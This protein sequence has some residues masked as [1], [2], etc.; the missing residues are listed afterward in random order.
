MTVSEYEA[1]FHELSRHAAMILPTEEERVR[2]FVRGLRLQLRIETQSLVSAGRSFLDVVDHART[3]EQLRREAQEGSGKRARQ[4]DSCDRR[5]FRPRESYDRSQQRFHSGQSSSPFQASLQ[6]SKGDQHCHIGFSVGPSRGRDSS[7]MGSSGRGSRPPA[8]SRQSQGCYECRELD[9]WARECPHRRLALPAPQAVRHAPA[10]S[11]RGRG[12]GQD[13]RGG[14]QGIRGG[15]RGGRLGGRADAQGRG[16]QAHFYAAPARADAETSDDVITGTVLLCQQPALALFDPGSTFSYVSVYYASRLS[17]M[18]EPL[19][20]P[21]RVSTPVGESLVVDQVF[22][23]CLVTIQ[24]HDTRADLILLDMVDFD[25]ILG[26]D[27]LSP[28]RAVLDCFSK[29]VTL[30]I[31]GIPP[32]VWQGSRSS[33]PVG[34]ISFIRARRLVASGCLSYLAYVRDVSR[35]VSPVESVPVVRDFIDVFPTDLPGLPPER[36]V[37]F[38]IELEPGTRPIFIPPYRMAPAELKELS[39]QLQDL[40]GKGFIRPSV[41]PWGAP[42]LFVK[43]KDGTM[44][45]CIDYR[46]LNKVTVKN[47]YPMPRINDLFDQLQGAVV[48]SKIDLRSGYHQ[49]RI[50]AADV[51]K[52]AFRTRY[53]HYEFLVMS[54]GLTNAPAAFMDLMTRVFRPYLDLFVIVFI[55]DILVYSRSRNKQHLRIVLQTLR[56][57]RLYAKFSKCEFWLESVAFLGHVVSKEGIRVDPAKIEAIRDWHRPTSVTEIRSFVGLAGYYRRFVEGFSTIAAPLT[58]LTRQDVPFVWSEECEASFLRLKELLTTAP[59]LTLPVEGEGFTVYCDASGV[60]LGCVL[61]QQGRVIAYASRQLKIHERNYPT[62]DLELAAVVFALKIWRHYLYGVRCE[63][64]T[65]HRS[66][67]Y[68]ISQRDLN[69][70][71]RRW[72]ELLKDYDLSILYHPGKANVVAD[73][74]SRKAVSMGSL[75]FLSS[76]ERPLALDIS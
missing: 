27:W 74:L 67:Q 25:V 53:G 17:L 9:H 75:A 58:R 16:V 8:L 50:R 55:D 59:I 23:S 62:H 33:T 42:V 20:A 36:D 41:S 11:A 73:A 71:Q 51:P 31:P 1:R 63:I 24:G 60:G 44:R 7:Q 65:D 18:S 48:F 68:I 26:M 10:P 52:T 47:R 32:V 28:Y 6:A 22:R 46:Q 69:S 38:P 34:V 19:V 43:K 2:C 72:I 64:Y 12:Q 56:D 3:I 21:L 40:L 70:R 37:D 54:F 29:T 14:H 49:L 76:T 57:Q 30:A 35:D 39:V 4:E 61:M 5:R 66:L 45:L 15:P 13:R